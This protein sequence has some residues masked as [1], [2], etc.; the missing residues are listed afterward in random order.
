MIAMKGKIKIVEPIIS[1]GMIRLGM[2]G[3]G[4]RSQTKTLWEN[5]GNVIIH[6]KCIAGRGSKLIIND[7]ATLILGD[8]F[9]IS[10]NSEVICKTKVT[11]G[12][13]CLLSWDILIMDSDMH[14]IFQ[15]CEYVNPDKPVVIGNHVWIGCRTS[16]LKG[17]IIPDNTI[18]ASNSVI[19]KSF[20]EDKCII[21]NNRIIKQNISWKY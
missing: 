16:I 14:K 5:R 9:T 3:L 7:N 18:I 6:G 15:N 21:S 10:S 19:T 13:D 1:P 8:N 4:N 17:V 2:V 12:N 20:K 11:F